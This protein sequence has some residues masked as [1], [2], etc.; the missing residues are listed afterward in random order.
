MMGTQGLQD[1]DTVMS[2]NYVYFN[3][4]KYVTDVELKCQYNF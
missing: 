3:S 2:E 4:I 1:A